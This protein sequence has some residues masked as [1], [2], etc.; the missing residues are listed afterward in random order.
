[1][2]FFQ[3]VEKRI[4]FL[5]NSFFNVRINMTNANPPSSR[6]TMESVRTAIQLFA[7]VI[8]DL[9]KVA[10][11]RG[12]EIDVLSRRI[13]DLEQTI[14]FIDTEIDDVMA[15]GKRIINEETLAKANRRKR[16][17]KAKVEAKH[18]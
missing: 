15:I 4:F 10:P 8:A 13:T 18:A 17:A 6:N 11:D 12:S 3:Y 5:Q 1:M 16:R 9:K 2:S 7:T 14:A